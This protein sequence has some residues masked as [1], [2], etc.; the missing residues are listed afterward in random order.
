MEASFRCV[1]SLWK[2]VIKEKF[3]HARKLAN[4]VKGP[5]GV[6][7]WKSI[8]NLLSKF[9]TK[10]NVKIDNGMKPFFLGKQLVWKWCFYRA[11]FGHL[12][13]QSTIK[14]NSWRSK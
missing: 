6:R 7:L 13:D 4:I 12:L 11:L 1:H 8:R 3:L 14:G 9:I 2:E 10:V 5:C